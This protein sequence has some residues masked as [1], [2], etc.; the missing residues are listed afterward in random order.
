MIPFFSFRVDQD[1]ET[2]LE[3]IELAKVEKNENGKLCFD[4]IFEHDQLSLSRQKGEIL[5]GKLIHLE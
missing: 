3:E 5:I 2:V 1:Q 4:S